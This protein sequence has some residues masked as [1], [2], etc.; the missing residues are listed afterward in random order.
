M[1][2]LREIISQIDL[3]NTPQSSPDW[4]ELSSL[5]NINNLYW[6]DDPRLKCYQIKK[7]LCTDTHVG[8]NAYFLDDVFIGIS[9]Q[10]Y[11]KSIPEFKL[12][13]KTKTI[14]YEYLI[15]L[16][17]QPEFHIDTLSD[18]DLDNEIPNTF[19]I[20]Y[21]SQIL[22]KSALLNGERVK[23]IKTIYDWNDKENYFH[24]VKI[25]KPNKDIIEV[26]IN[27]L[28]FEYNV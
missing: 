13:D 7:W 27:T 11:R 12:M 1:T 26:H 21:N 28:D 23:I 5:F 18:N 4:E 9:E 2:T 22:H 10:K 3:D 6:S 16:V 14:L 25:Q 19:K 20:E 24:T 15:S 17:D 8:I